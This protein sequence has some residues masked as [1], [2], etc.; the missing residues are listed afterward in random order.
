[1]P[2]TNQSSMLVKA[3]AAAPELPE[4]HDAEMTEQTAAELRALCAEK[5][6]EFDTALTEA[7][8]RERIVA[9]GDMD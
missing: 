2:K 1:M 6:V 3:P 9:L 4:T 8:A 7:Q 5:G